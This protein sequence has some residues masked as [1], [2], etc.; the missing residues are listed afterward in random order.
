MRGEK[1]G[2]GISDGKEKGVLNSPGDSAGER[3]VKKSRVP[4]P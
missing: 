3:N 1:L 4:G 2:G